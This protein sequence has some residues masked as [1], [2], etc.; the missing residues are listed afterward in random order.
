MAN[1]SDLNADLN[2]Q[3]N[4]R[5]R[6]M[7]DESNQGVTFSKRDYYSLFLAGLVLPAIL[8]I[9]GWFL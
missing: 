7:E 2:N 1:G 6:M 8:M 9:L 4:K 3:L 5:L